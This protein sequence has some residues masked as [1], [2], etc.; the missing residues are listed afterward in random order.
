MRGDTKVCSGA[1]LTKERWNTSALQV[2]DLNTRTCVRTFTDH[3][4]QVGAP[5]HGTPIA[6]RAL[7]DRFDRRGC[8][9][10]K[11]RDGKEEFD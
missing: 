6:T 4:D 1:M 7:P 11:R 5:E 8:T 9:G 10:G 3:S 2:W